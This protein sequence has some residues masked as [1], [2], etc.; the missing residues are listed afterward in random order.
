MEKTV[1]YKR[2]LRGSVGAGVG[3]LFNGKGRRYYILEHKDA[4]KYH[5]AGESQKIIIDQVELGRD[6]HCQV[7]FDE[8]FSTVSR[9]H[10]AIVKDG[11][12]W[13]LV[14][15]SHTNST[16]LNGHPV[17]KEWYL[18]NGDEIQLSI[19]G[20]RIGFIV[21]AGKQSLV[22]SIKMTERL[23]L[24]RKQALKP[25][26]TAIACL[27]ITLVLAVGGLTT[28][29]VIEHNY[30]E[31]E[32]AKAIA[33]ADSLE[34]NLLEMNDKLVYN[35]KESDSINKA[36]AKRNAAL[37]NK[38]FSLSAAINNIKAVSAIANDAAVQKAL[39]SVYYI[40][41]ERIDVTLPDG[42]TK[43][44]T[45]GENGCFY[46]GSGFLLNDGRFIT[47]RHVADGIKCIQDPVKE[48]LF[49]ELNM[50]E[51]QG[52]KVVIT[53]SAYSP[54]HSFSFTSEQCIMSNVNKNI[55]LENGAK[56]TL[57]VLGKQ[58]WA[59][60]RTSF[61]GN[62][63]ANPSIS[64]SLKQRTK[65]IVLGYPAGFFANNI[66]A[67]N[68]SCMVAADGLNDGVI[69]ITERNFEGGNSGGP[70]FRVKSDGNIEAVGLISAG[71]GNTVGFIVPLA[72]IK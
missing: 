29:N 6:S 71:Y 31:E 64:T 70:V 33:R 68:G 45:N 51:N 54:T 3:A 27:S 46:T 56:V 62:I 7:R 4:S 10:A 19:G 44:L 47:A 39:N 49:F 41:A 25:Y 63:S 20:P 26:K 16:L 15:L 37:Y 35:K 50:L 58:D 21:P 60:L 42:E 34:Y 23:E 11:E 12:R 32:Q 53:F 65:L 48:K 67:I 59:Y 40:R 24:F 1:Q 5:K 69:V 61:K 18:Q 14:Q 13:K 52:A 55:T 22:S 72:N 57:A 30:W 2:T 28:W 38:T 8:S 66:K 36:Q 17:E 43:T 9:R